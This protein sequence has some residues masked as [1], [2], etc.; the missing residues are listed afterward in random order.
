MDVCCARYS[1]GAHASHLALVPNRGWPARSRGDFW[2]SQPGAGGQ[3]DC[4]GYS[5]ILE[6]S[7]FTR[8]PVPVR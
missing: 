1:T 7:T 6:H 2:G 5:M 8:V 4:Y 3:L